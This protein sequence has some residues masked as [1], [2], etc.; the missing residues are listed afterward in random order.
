MAT[1]VAAKTDASTIPAYPRTVD[2]VLQDLEEAILRERIGPGERLIELSIAERFGVGRTTVREALLML[3][4]RGLVVSVPR[5]G[6]FVTRISREDALD[7]AYSRALLEAFAVRVGWPNIDRAVIARLRGQLAEMRIYRFPD[8]VPQM[9]KIDLAF[10]RT[11]V[12]TAHMPR[13]QEL[14]SSLD[15]QIG[16]LYIRGIEEQHFDTGAVADLHEN[17]IAG[18]QSG[19]PQ[20][21]QRAIL[22]HY[23]RA[24]HLAS[25]R[26]EALTDIV[27]VFAMTT[28][29][30]MS[31]T[32]TRRVS[33]SGQPRGE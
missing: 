5:R 24:D 9:I 2:H 11:L 15:G 14:W 21:A 19:D 6:T 23:V 25:L 16:A 1:D 17:V 20:I 12:E 26:S 7:L 31:S 29:P 4:Q 32:A 3:Q 30:G 13:L 27:S 22:T 18:L 33:W 10:H 8:D 28:R